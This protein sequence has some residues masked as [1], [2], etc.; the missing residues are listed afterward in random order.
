[1]TWDTHAAVRAALWYVGITAAAILVWFLAQYTRYD[2]QGTAGAIY[3]L[4]RLTGAVELC[5]GKTIHPVAPGDAE[6]LRIVCS[7]EISRY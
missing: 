6:R 1:M 7:D 4:D 2:I 5:T 3:R